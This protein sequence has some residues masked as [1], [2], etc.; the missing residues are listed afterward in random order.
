MP[1]SEDIDSI[2]QVTSVRHA[3]L[4]TYDIFILYIARK[5]FQKFH[6]LL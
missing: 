6:F 5:E 4:R 3:S 1:P 2:A